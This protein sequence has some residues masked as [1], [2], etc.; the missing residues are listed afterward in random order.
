LLSKPSINFMDSLPLLPGYK[1]LIAESL[2]C[3]GCL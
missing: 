2:L 3:F 1:I